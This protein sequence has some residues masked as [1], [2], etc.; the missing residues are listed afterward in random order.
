MIDSS[1][2]VD[3]GMSTNCASSNVYECHPQL[4]FKQAA[5]LVNEIIKI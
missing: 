2:F 4:M 1:W 3:N 5:R